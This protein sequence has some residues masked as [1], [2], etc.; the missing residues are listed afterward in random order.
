MDLIWNNTLAEQINQQTQQA[1]S[2]QVSGLPDEIFRPKAI[3][4][5]FF[6]ND[7]YKISEYIRN[8]FER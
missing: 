3:P 2:G 1:F 5:D 4:H 6:Y 7:M 8:I